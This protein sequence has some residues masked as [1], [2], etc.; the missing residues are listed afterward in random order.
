MMKAQSTS[1]ASRLLLASAA[2][3]AGLYWF[4]DLLTP[5]ALAIFLW[6]TMDAFAQSLSRRLPFLPRVAAVPL[7]VLIVFISL[8]GI[9]GFVIEYAAVFSRSIGAY[10]ERLDQVIHQTYA[11]LGLSGT[12]PTVGEMF[13]KV[14]PALILRGVADALQS[15]GGQAL[16]VIIYVACL[17][18]A[19]ASMPAKMAQIFPDE[20]ERAKASQTGRAIARSMEQYLWV[21]TV[22]GLMIAG[23]SWVLFA[24]VGLQNGLFWAIIIFV[25]SYI[26]VVGGAAGSLLPALFA[27]VQFTSPI[28]AVIILAGTQA[29]GFVVGNIIQPR[30]TGDSLNISVLVVFL[31]LAFWG[32]LW[33]GPGMFLAVPLTVMLMI[34]LAQFPA[35]RWIAV[36][37]SNNGNP[38]INPDPDDADQ[39][40]VKSV[41]AAHTQG[42][43]KEETTTS[44][45]DSSKI[46]VKPS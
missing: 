22:T 19:Q 18:A 33:G 39:S 44:Q 10:Q 36:L 42:A 23:A 24:L 29:I 31:S 12:A 43:V 34:V 16:F 37:L 13:A 1:S 30:M 2:I 5:L 40:G 46:E 41:S 38:D 17:F 20:A 28:P 15:F 25:L 26:P 6:L 8:A 27:L 32:K 21:Q 14:N 9:V 35:T 11:L 4:A 3:I 7:A 45:D